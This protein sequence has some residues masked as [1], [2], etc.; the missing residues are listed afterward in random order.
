MG[1]GA[2]GGSSMLGGRYDS[3]QKDHK[4]IILNMIKEIAKSNKFVHKGDIQT[5]VQRSISSNDFEVALDS[6]LNDGVIC[7]A[8]EKDIFT[9][10]E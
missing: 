10:T 5:M 9:I 7:E 4:Q 6:L 8:Y 3:N 1:A 2:I